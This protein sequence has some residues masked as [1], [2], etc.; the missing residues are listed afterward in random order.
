MKSQKCILIV[1]DDADVL[2]F[3]GDRLNA[4]GY[5]VLTASNGKEGAD[6]LQDQIVDGVLLDLYMPVMGGLL[7]LEQLAQSSAIPPVIIMSAPEHRSELQLGIVKGAKDFLFKP[8][9][10]DEL[11]NKCK[12]LFH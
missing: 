10:P 12:R 8:I 9:A 3:L 1:D 5:E 4:L 11:T 6:A 7:L 2:L